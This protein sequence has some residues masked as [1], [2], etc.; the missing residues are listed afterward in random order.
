MET[1]L[2][3]RQA[4]EPALAQANLE[5]IQRLT[6]LRQVMDVLFLSHMELAI[7]RSEAAREHS[8]SLVTGYLCVGF[9]D[10]VGFTQLSQQLPVAELR[11]LVDDFESAEYDVVGSGGRVVKLIGDEVMF[12]TVD[13]TAARR[14]AS[15][16]S[17]ASATTPPSCPRRRSPWGRCSS[18]AATTTAPW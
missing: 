11:T 14:S 1:P 6:P 7:I 9:V 5:A 18:V 16:C 3:E 17:N 13:P 10:L 12:V 4:G 2:A 8:T 15:H